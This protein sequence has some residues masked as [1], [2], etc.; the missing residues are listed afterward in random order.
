MTNEIQFVLYNLDQEDVKVKV[1]IQDE[2]IWVTQRGMAEL[3]GVNTPAI[4]KHLSNIYEE[5][6]LEPSATV[7]KMEIVQTEGARQVTRTVDFYN[8]DAVISVGY[9]VNSHRATQFRIWATG[10]LKEFIKKGFVLDDNRL[11]QGETVFGKDYFKELLERVRSIR[12]SERRIWLQ[13]TDIFAECSIDYDKNSPITQEF[14]AT[15]QN[16]FHYAITGQ[17]AA[18][19]IYSKAD[20]TQENMGLTTWKHSPDGRILKSD[21]T[22]A[23]NYLDEKQIKRLERTVSGFFDYVEDLIEEEH[24]FTMKDFAEAINAFLEFRKYKILQGKG[25]VSKLTA[26]TKAVQEYDIFNK[27]QKITSDF[28]RE[29]KKLIDKKDN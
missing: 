16:K 20:S 19:I 9:R 21:V 3:F 28:D 1:A 5:G 17:T 14:Y 6:E 22:I 8:L 27:T 23:K 12:A 11:K 24:A 4:S 10:V 26:D 7:S 25:T 13:I 18:E 15:V 2:T 29:V